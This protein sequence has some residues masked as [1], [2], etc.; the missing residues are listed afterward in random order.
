V[1]TVWHAGISA[2]TAAIPTM[3]VSVISFF[4]CLV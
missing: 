4:I 2:K 3:L 1:A